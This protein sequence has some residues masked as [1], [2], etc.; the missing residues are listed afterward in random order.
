MFL[1]S[2]EEDPETPDGPLSI[3]LTPDEDFQ[4]APGDT[5]EINVDVV[6]ASADAEVTVLSDAGGTFVGDNVVLSGESIQ[7]VVPSDAT[8]GELI[9]LTF[10]VTDGTVQESEQIGITVGYET[11]VD[12]ALRNDGFETLVAALTEAELVDDLQA[13]GPFTVFAPTDDAFADLELTADELLA[14]DILDSVLLYHVVPGLNLA[15]DLTTGYYETLNGDSVYI[16]NDNGVFVNGVEVDIPD[17]EANNGVVHA[18]GEVLYPNVTTYETFLLA[19]PLAEGNSE[20]FFSTSTG[21]IYSFDEVVGTS[22]PV[23]S[24]IDFGYFY[25]N[26]ALASLLSPDN[27]NWTNTVQ[28]DMNEWTERNT[29]V[30]RTTTV[31]ATEFDAIS[32][33]E[34]DLLESA[35]VEFGT[36]VPNPG[37]VSGLEAND[38][39]AFQTED[40]RFGLVK[41]VEVIGTTGS[42]DGI[43]I[44]VKVTQ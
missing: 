8:L 44:Q 5:V 21:E 40:G 28:Y 16:L 36:D 33:S 34:A 27:V 41:I 24:T 6:N 4:A 43:R 14:S 20:T 42:N 23:S 11:V 39:I 22:E 17:L 18:I 13:D 10:S 31:G 15:A 32:S 3:N 7:F 29:T 1:A 35:F 19:A 2:C 26:T 30:F 38:V 25:G 37:R 9:T 12:V